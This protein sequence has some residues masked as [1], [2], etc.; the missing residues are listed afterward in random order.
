MISMVSVPLM[1]KGISI[2]SMIPPNLSRVVCHGPGL[3]R[4]DLHYYICPLQ[5][6]EFLQSLIHITV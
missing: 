1:S 5:S 3:S 2:S 6:L 4:P